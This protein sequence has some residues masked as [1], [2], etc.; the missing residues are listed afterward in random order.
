MSKLDNIALCVAFA[1]TIAGGRDHNALQEA[2]LERAAS[3]PEPDSN[4]AKLNPPPPFTQRADYIV[5]PP[6]VIDVHVQEALPGRPIAFKYLVRPDGKISLGFYGEVFVAGLTVPEIKIKIIDRMRLFIRDEVLGLLVLDDNGEPLVDP[7][8]GKA[9]SID[10]KDSKAVQVKLAQCR[11]K[12]FYVWGEVLKPGQFP[13]TGMQTI[14]DAINLA[15]G[16]SP[17]ADREKVVLHRVGSQRAMQSFTFDLDQIKRH[18]LPL[19]D[20]RL[21]PGDR[22]VVR[23]SAEHHA[24][25]GNRGPKPSRAPSRLRPEIDPATPEPAI[26]HSERD[27]VPTEDLS[28]RHLEKRMADLEHKLDLILETVKK[29]AD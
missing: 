10:P 27:E 12:Y 4:A 28:T 2:R 13:V 24:A 26:E 8:N 23:S 21:K 17:L 16:L 29:P 25:T 9:K 14:L 18:A 1:C 7:A 20:D 6:D 11:S 3:Q 22:L 5:E 15:G 19:A